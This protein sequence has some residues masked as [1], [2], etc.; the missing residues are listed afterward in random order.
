MSVVSGGLTRGSAVVG[1][2][3]LPRLLSLPHSAGPGAPSGLGSPQGRDLTS[4][5]GASRGRSPGRG[6]RQLRGLCARLPVS[7]C[8]RVC[9]CVQPSA[10]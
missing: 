4:G 7:A 6:G 10:P 8:A 3:E 5:E 9:A 1:T 2:G